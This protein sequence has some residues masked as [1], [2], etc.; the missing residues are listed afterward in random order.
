MS[1]TSQIQWYA[2]ILARDLIKNK[3]VFQSFLAVMKSQYYSVSELEYFQNLKLKELIK[4][5]YETVPYYRITM[6]KFKLTPND[7]NSKNDLVKLPVLTKKKINEIGMKQFISTSLSKNQL[8]FGSTGGTTGEPFIFC[9]NNKYSNTFEAYLLRHYSWCGWQPGD[10]I[11]RLWGRPITESHLRKLKTNMRQLV[12]K[13]TV[14]D[15]FK[16]S[17]D[18]MD[19]YADKIDK[20]SPKILRGYANSLYLFAKYLK[21]SGRGLNIPS[22]SSTAEM[23]FP[24]YREEIKDSLSADCFN[25]YGCGEIRNI[26]VECEAHNGLHVNDEHVIVEVTQRITTKNDVGELVIT[27]LDNYG[28]PFIRYENGDLARTIMGKCSCGRKLS[29]IGEIAG[30]V[31]SSFVTKTGTIVHGEFITHLLNESK[32]AKDMGIR[33]FQM[34]QNDFDKYKLNIVSKRKLNKSET[35]YLTSIL[36]KYLGSIKLNIDYFKNVPVTKA[37][38]K[39]FTISEIIPR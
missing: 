27:D 4:H 39:Q 11:V 34:I 37:G 36:E 2:V 1:L 22:C 16:M 6:N 35:N 33:E 5:A 32:I 26:A 25:Q 30:R 7:F 23:L 31:S 15:S 17:M 14:F 21:K 19:E 13:D 24:Y 20:F 8:Y 9:K 28:M 10:K 18:H 29:R 3:K 12:L 38:K